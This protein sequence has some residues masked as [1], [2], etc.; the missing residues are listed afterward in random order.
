MIYLGLFLNDVYNQ[1]LLN[2]WQI[3][4]GPVLKTRYCD[5][6]TLKFGLNQK[7][8][9]QYLLDNNVKLGSM[10]SIKVIGY[11]M[12]PSC[13]AVLCESPLPCDNAF[14]HITVA[15]SGVAPK[16]SNSLMEEA[17]NKGYLIKINDGPKLNAI[18][19]VYPRTAK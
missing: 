14:P 13:Q 3:V 10:H 17:N 18:L 4:L 2:W 8:L 19:D 7:I 15:T 11:A 16:Y 9:D 5:H 1:S 6:L 12:D